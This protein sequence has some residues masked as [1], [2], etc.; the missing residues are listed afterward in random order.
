MTH[1]QPQMPPKPPGDDV[2][3]FLPDHDGQQLFEWAN[4]AASIEQHHGHA[5]GGGMGEE[6]RPDFRG[7]SV[8]ESA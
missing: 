8:R 5:S 7:A 2:R 4:Q 3:G 1:P 6:I